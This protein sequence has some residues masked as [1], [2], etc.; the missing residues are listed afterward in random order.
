MKKLLL[1][2]FCLL[3]FVA[4]YAGTADLETM[5]GGKSTNSYGS[6]NSTAGWS[7]VNSVILQG[8]AT[9]GEDKN[10]VYG[11]IG[12]ASTFA[13]CLNGKT[14]AVGKL[15][16]PTLSGGIGTLTLNYGLPYSDT[17]F[18]CTVNILQG[19]TVVASADIAPE[20]ITK[21]TKYDFS[22][23]LNVA[24]DFVIEIVNNSPSNSTSNKDRSA[25]WNISWTEYSTGVVTNVSIPKITPNGGEI[26]ADTEISISCATEGATIYY[27]TDGSD[28][29]TSST[30]YAAPFKLSAAAT[31]KAIAVA[32]GL[33]NSS[34]ATANFTFPFANIAEFIAGE[35][36]TART[37]A[38]TVKVVA[39]GGKY[40]VVTDDSGSILIYGDLGTTY[41]AGDEL[42]GVKGS[43][44]VFN[45]MIQLTNPVMPTAVAGTP[46]EPTEATLDVVAL[47]NL[48]DYVKITGITIP[49]GT[50]KSFTITDANG[51][52]ATLYN[53]FGISITAGSN[54]TVVGVVGC[55]KTAQLWPVE[56]TNAAGLEKVVAPV[57]SPDGGEVAA[58]QEIAITCATEGA[59]IYY[60]LDGNDPTSSSTLY[61]A[62][63]TL[64]ASATVKAVAIAEGMENSDVVSAEFTVNDNLKVATFDFTNP[65]SLNP[66]QTVAPD[67]EG[68]AALDGV[69]LTNA[70]ASIT[71]AQGT[72][73]AD[74]RIFLSTKEGFV[75]DFRAYKGSSFTI[76]VAD[77]YV[78]SS[79]EFEGGK[80]GNSCWT[81]SVGTADATSW[82]GGEETF[83][84]VT[85]NSIKT[86]NVQVIRVN[87]TKGEP[88]SVESIV[89]DENAPVV[90]YNLQGIRVAEPE[91]GIFIRV[92]GEKTTK[93]LLKK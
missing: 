9:D 71:F 44:S 55:Y 51:N 50:G 58:N 56:I 92:Q 12:D 65:S 39:Q 45:G 18:N 78:I 40:L 23:E 19:G 26:T 5:N 15:T 29:T 81:A 93:V 59:Q 33:E 24:G 8:R 68:A 67:D 61:A 32:T 57:I 11:F 35:P 2:I 20:S 91:N 49:D 79:I 28:P 87:Y 83:R 85:F 47:E 7:V 75:P 69:T 38:G 6:Y 17:K 13:V 22:A 27:T 21:L 54:L 77:G 1:S 88:S 30:L 63:F 16:S 36:T 37:I 31:V 76:A 10:P 84:S 34:I 70:D 60:T 41:N 25:I 14:T 46:V 42:T 74:I 86:C 66:A 52:E 48:Y 89:V 62:P 72:A 4:A 82:T 43:Y 80:V 64:D 73:T 90:Y 3:G 53:Q